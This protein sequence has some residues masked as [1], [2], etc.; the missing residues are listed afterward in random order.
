[1]RPERLQV[2]GDQFPMDP[3]GRDPQVD[4]DAVA[5][6]CQSVEEVFGT[7]SGIAAATGDLFGGGQHRP[8]DITVETLEHHITFLY[9]LCTAWRD[10]P[11]ASPICSHVHPARRAVITCRASRLSASRRR[12]ATA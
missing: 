11:R 3:L 10:T 2:P 9:F 4:G 1:H 6:G 12:A 5:Y 8:P 7:Q